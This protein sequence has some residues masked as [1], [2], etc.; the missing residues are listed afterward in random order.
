ME[1]KD[2]D[3]LIKVSEQILDLR[4]KMVD[5]KGAL[6]RID[7]KFD[8]Q[9]VNGLQQIATCNAAIASKLDT[10]WFKWIVAILVAVLMS[11]A[12]L[13]TTTRLHMDKIEQSLELHKAT[14]EKHFKESQFR[15]NSLCRELEIKYIPYDV[16]IRDISH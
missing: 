3:L 4:E 12:G 14:T 10:T 13:A 1:Q 2:H 7:K 9:T 15:L 6:N 8:D 11:I 16:E 5:F